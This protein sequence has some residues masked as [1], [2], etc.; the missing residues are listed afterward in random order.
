MGCPNHTLQATQSLWQQEQVATFLLPFTP[1]KGCLS[2]MVKTSDV[3]TTPNH[4]ISTQNPIQAA[5]SSCLDEGR[6]ALAELW[7]ACLPWA[8]CWLP[9][10]ALSA[11]SSR[12]LPSIHHFSFATRRASE[13]NWKS[14]WSVTQTWSLLTA[15]YQTH[16]TFMHDVA[17]AVITVLRFSIL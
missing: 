8:A 9:L 7:G 5:M 1:F 16:Q 4:C 10:A 14:L 2:Q 6:W 11:C 15:I 12:T 3:W 13:L 17:S